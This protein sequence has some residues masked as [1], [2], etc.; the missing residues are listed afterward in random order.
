MRTTQCFWP[1]ELMVRGNDRRVVVLGAPVPRK[2]SGAREQ[3]TAKE[4]WAHQSHGCRWPPTL[5]LRELRK[6]EAAVL[7]VQLSENC[8]S[9]S[10]GRL[11]PISPSLPITCEYPQKL[12][13]QNTAPYPRAKTSA[14]N[15]SKTPQ[16]PKNAGWDRATP[17][18]PTFMQTNFSAWVGRTSQ[19]L[20]W[21]IQW[22]FF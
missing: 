8:C 18:A 6:K 16:A 1:E 14:M 15:G 3:T 4:R 13:G 7:A 22:T 20:R 10:K 17:P 21:C 9:S 11:T 2:S 19:I 12:C 5:S